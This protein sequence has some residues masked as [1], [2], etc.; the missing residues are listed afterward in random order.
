MTSTGL[1]AVEARAAASGGANK[2]AYVRRIFSEIAP[3]YDLL[4]HLLSAGID[5]RWRTRAIASLGLTG[6]ETLLDV[7]TGTA[8]VALE[9]RAERRSAGHSTA[10]R[11]VGVDF[12][13]I[14]PE[15]ST[16]TTRAAAE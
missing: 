5:K 12:S 9:A 7:C 1:N 3:R 4:N 2:R 8:D 14:L 10:A 11:V 13:S 16:P 15:K 6:R